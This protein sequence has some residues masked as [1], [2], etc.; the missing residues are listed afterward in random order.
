MQGKT[1]LNK[2]GSD[3]EK[4][5][6]QDR[7][8][9][10]SKDFMLPFSEDNIKYLSRKLALDFGSSELM[11]NEF[12]IQLTEFREWLNYLVELLK[13]PQVAEQEDSAENLT[14]FDALIGQNY[15][16]F[17]RILHDGND[18][19]SRKIGQKPL[20]YYALNPLLVNNN[21][22]FFTALAERMDE[23]PDN[24][25]GT[26]LFELIL[27]FND[28]IVKIKRALAVCSEHDL[29]WNFAQW[30]KQLASDSM[31][32]NLLFLMAESQKD[33]LFIILFI[34]VIV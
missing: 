20:L 6:L 16:A 12:Y 10:L 30:K 2:L 24:I 14:L 31:N 33:K 4:Q 8:S 19:L 11:Q 26:S 28:D 13:N 27:N 23:L 15:P 21:I 25:G 7:L 29:T 34:T 17:K 22:S 18:D 1:I 5:V 32:E 9:T 3:E